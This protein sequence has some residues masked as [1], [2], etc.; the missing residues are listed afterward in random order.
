MATT[1]CVATFGLVG[2]RA[3]ISIG[4][5]VPE[6]VTE[7]IPV[8]RNSANRTTITMTITLR[9]CRSSSICSK[10]VIR[11]SLGRSASEATFA[12][13]V[14]AAKRARLMYFP[15]MQGC[16][17]PS[18]GVAVLG[19]RIRGVAV[20]ADF[21]VPE[22]FLVRERDGAHPLCTLVGVALRHEEPDRTPVFDRKRL[23]VPPVGEQ[24]VGI[25]EDVERMGRRIAVAAPKG[26]KAGGRSDLRTL[27]HFAD[28]DPEPLVVERGPAR[29]AVEWRNHFCGRKSQELVVG[30]TDRF[31][32]RAVH[33]EVPLLRVEARDD[34][35]VEPRPFPDL[36]LPGRETPLHSHPTET[37]E[38]PRYKSLCRC[39]ARIFGARL[40]A[41][42]R[43]D[44]SPRYREKTR[45]SCAPTKV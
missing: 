11:R 19:Q 41:S 44:A 39:S 45:G 2:P 9:R 5:C 29:D 32:D 8:V 35:Q 17:S 30:E 4:I 1:N 23:A 16:E 28:R 43:R 31:V 36:P 6:T 37:I 26:R 7:P 42:S 22:L 20:P 24:D 25:V 15:Q 27:R 34:A 12:T 14:I 13:A 18:E 21:P 3:G 33:A 40:D 38:I 10:N